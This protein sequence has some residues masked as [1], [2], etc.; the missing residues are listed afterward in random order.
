MSIEAELAHPR[1]RTPIR[2]GMVLCHPH[3][4]HGGTMRSIV[5]SALFGALPDAGVACL[6]F[7]FRGVE[8]SG[9]EH[10]FGDGERHDARA[11]IG[12]IA[13]AP[14]P[15][16]AV[17]ARRA[18]RSERTSTLSVHDD[19][20]AAWFAIAAPL[21]SVLDVDA[22]ASDPRPKLLA[23]AERDEIRAP[24]EV[25]AEV[26]GWTNTTVAVVSGASHFFVGRTDPLLVHARELVDQ[27]TGRPD[28]RQAPPRGSR[29]SCGGRGESLAVEERHALGHGALPGLEVEVVEGPVTLFD[30]VLE[31][32][33]CG[34]LG[35]EEL[36]IPPQEPVVDHAVR[37]QRNP[38]VPR[39]TPDG[40]AVDRS[41][42]P[43]PTRQPLAH[44]RSAAIPSATV[45]RS[46]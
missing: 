24:A 29:R 3:P 4:L 23:L 16:R 14:R 27:L 35:I 11:A 6:R 8:A 5:I 13:P 25:E 7:N 37:I 40:S 46:S 39:G 30:R 18:G 1:R 44:G 31:L 43:Y 45:K 36:A 2:A 33:E 34:I 28:P 32:V 15:E 12:S 17:G 22:V 38:L 41:R 20:L 10:D 19:R 9:G 42:R 21:R 26:A